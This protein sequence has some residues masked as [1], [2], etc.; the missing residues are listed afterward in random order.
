MPQWTQTAAIY[1]RGYLSHDAGVPLESVEWVQSGVNQAGRIEK[2]KLK[3]PSGLKYR[4]VPDRSMTDMLLAGDIDAVLSARPPHALGRGVRR[5]FENYEQVEEAYFRK[6][7]IFPIMHVLA[8]KTDVLARYPWLAMNLY[9]AFDEA[10]R[11]S[12][13][14]FE[15]ITASYAPFA[16]LR[17]YSDRMKALFGQ[18]FWPYGLEPSRKTL[19]AFLL[20]A[21]EQGVCHRRVVPEELFPRE[22]LTSYKV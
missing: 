1:A 9:K 19:E 4:S 10:K 22:V 20:F 18:D 12:M 8:V 3:L 13:A 21:H 15:D 14:R 2:M 17:P 6:T 11:R 7:G 5:L 16:W